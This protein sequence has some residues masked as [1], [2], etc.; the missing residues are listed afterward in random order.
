MS[1]VL[2]AL[3]LEGDDVLEGDCPGGGGNDV[4]RSVVGVEASMENRKEMAEEEEL[5]DRSYGEDFY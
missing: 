5:S 1:D 3:D 2:H 4:G